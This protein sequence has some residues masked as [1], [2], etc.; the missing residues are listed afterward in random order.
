MCVCEIL[1]PSLPFSK[2]VELVVWSPTLPAKWRDVLS[3]DG[4][5]KIKCINHGFWNEMSFFKGCDMLW[6]ASV[7][8][9]KVCKKKKA[10]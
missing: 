3:G 9:L 6:Q 1:D 7:I 4:W 10:S 2:A 8:C 5:I